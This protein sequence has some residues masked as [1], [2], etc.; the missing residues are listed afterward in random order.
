MQTSDSISR[1][2][3]ITGW[4]LSALVILFCLFDAFGKLTKPEAVIKGTVQMGYPESLITSIG[5]ILLVFTILYAIPRASLLGLV[6]L[7]GYLGGAVAS[8]M[9]IEAPLFSHIL[10]PVYF[11]IIAWTGLYLRSGKL[12]EL[13]K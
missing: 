4:I 11:A 13:V 9:R 8:T 5:V 2:S 3:R 10:F 1:K 7:T 12:R 6:L